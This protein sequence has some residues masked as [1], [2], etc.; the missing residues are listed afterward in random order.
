MR[1]T[2]TQ[3][4][5]FDA[6]CTVTHQRGPDEVVPCLSIDKARSILIHSGARI[7]LGQMSRVNPKLTKMRALDILLEW[8]AREEARGRTTLTV[9]ASKE[10]VREFLD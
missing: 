1:L 3:K 5:A 9:Q 7:L 10:I 8:V 2:K 4:A 6:T